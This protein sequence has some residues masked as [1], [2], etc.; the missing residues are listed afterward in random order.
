M[1]TAARE[2]TAKHCA[3]LLG[4]YGQI[5]R[6]HQG[7]VARLRDVESQ[8]Q[9]ISRQIEAVRASASDQV[10][11]EQMLKLVQLDDQ[12]QP[13]RRQQEWLTEQLEHEAS[14][15]RKIR[16]VAQQAAMASDYLGSEPR[17]RG[18]TDLAELAG[19]QILQAQEDERR[20]LARDVHDGPAQVLANAVF[21]LE[22]CKRMLTHDPNQLAAELENIE[23]DLRSGLDDVRQFIYDLSPASFTEVGLVVS[24]RR[25]LQKFS[26][27]T[28]VASR[29]LVDPDVERATGQVEMGAFRIIQEALQN[30][31]KHSHAT[32][33]VVT[34]KQDSSALRVAIEDNGI[35]FDRSAAS[36]PSDGRHF[37]LVSMSER[38]RLL[39][40]ELVIDSRP[41]NGTRISLIIPLSEPS[42]EM[43]DPGAL[44]DP[45]TES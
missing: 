11:P 43:G 40:G 39:H 26:E 4:L 9:E 5:R 32:D 36:M 7:H 37:G 14:A 33:V 10:D 27:R 38:A 16:A 1:L 20:R 8:L 19:F 31:R 24:L 30:V 6:V 25:Y 29:L 28:G 3:A 44:A 22:W 15:G 18:V 13:L 42:R 17:E 41:G 12:I 34:L 45:A 35:G 21:G 23:H 2:L